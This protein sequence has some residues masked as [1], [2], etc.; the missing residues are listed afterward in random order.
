M[1]EYRLRTLVDSVI[2]SDP[3]NLTYQTQNMWKVAESWQFSN[4]SRIFFFF[5]W[6]K[7]RI[8]DGYVKHSVLCIPDRLPVTSSSLILFI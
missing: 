3:A 6:F 5:R 1:R 4:K 2:V 8:V 7:K